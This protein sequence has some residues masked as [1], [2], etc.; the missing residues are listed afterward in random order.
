[1]K[2]SAFYAV[3][4]ATLFLGVL[5][6]TVQSNAAPA[7]AP[8]PVPRSVPDLSSMKMFMGS[9]SCSQPL[10]GKTRTDHS[11]TTMTLDGQYMMT[12]DVSPPFDKFRTRPVIADSYFTYNPLNKMWVTVGVDNFGTYFVNT[13][14]GWSG[15]TLKTTTK[16]TNDGSSGYDVLTKVSDTK[17]TDTF[18]NKDPKG[19]VTRATITCTKTG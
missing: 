13:S 9:W 15:N 3:G 18:V 16:L 2:T 5:G 7:A 6:G 12:H 14:P 1:M 11:T 4:I 8:T 17:T 19:K 10:R